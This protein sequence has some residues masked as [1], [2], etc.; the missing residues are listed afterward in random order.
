MKKKMGGKI[1]GCMVKFGDTLD[2]RYATDGKDI[3]C[4]TGLYYFVSYGRL[5]IKLNYK[6]DIYI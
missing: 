4:Y 6:L 3:L 2:F 1:W 5:Q